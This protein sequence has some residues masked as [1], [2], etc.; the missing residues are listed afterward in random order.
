MTVGVLRCRV[1]VAG[2]VLASFL[3]QSF[4]DQTVGESCDVINTC[5]D[6]AFCLP[7][8]WIAVGVQR[9]VP[10]ASDVLE[11]E[12]CH[13]F[14]NELVRDIAIAELE[15]DNA[16]FSAVTY[17]TGAEAAAGG[18][19]AGE[20]GVAYDTDGRYGCYTSLC[21][22]V[23]VSLGVSVFGTQG[24]WNRYEDIDGTSQAFWAGGGTL[25]TQIV[26]AVFAPPFEEGDLI[27]QVA[28][29]SIGVGLDAGGG[30]AECQTTLSTI[31]SPD[32][33]YVDSGNTGSEDGSTFAPFKT[34]DAG[35]AFSEQFVD[36][37]MPQVKVRASAAGNNFV[38]TSPG[39]YDKPMR[40]TAPDGP[41][42]LFASPPP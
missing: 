14:Y 37:P 18:T 26:A 7:M 1:F 32:D 8:P 40:I 4:A 41:I 23:G 20:I 9:C 27:G 35:Y 2:L 39:V 15:S 25:L 13:A 21:L 17:G 38:P 36:G 30:F 3:P 5:V 29:G 16:S 42:T 24:K 33:V 28:I 22:G 34:F 6:G 19:A 11:P 10:D 31:I 12:A